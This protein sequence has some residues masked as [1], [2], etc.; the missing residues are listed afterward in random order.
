VYVS[1]PTQSSDEGSTTNTT[2]DA[3][4]G[5]VV[6]DATFGEA[7]AT[8]SGSK[9]VRMPIGISTV[10]QAQVIRDLISSLPEP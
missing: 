4:L 1:L 8:L 5:I 6:R 9:P 10:V 3:I 2:T 7:A